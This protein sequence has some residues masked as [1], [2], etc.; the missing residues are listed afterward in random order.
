MRYLVAIFLILFSMQSFADET[1]DELRERMQLAEAP[2]NPTDMQSIERGAK[3]FANTCMSCHTMVYLKYDKLAKKAGI[4][5]D[6]MPV[7]VKDWPYGVKPPDLS[8]EA[9]LRGVNWLYTYLHSF[10][11]DKERPTGANN[12][13]V[14]MT[15]M[16]AILSPYQGEQALVKKAYGGGILYGDLQWYDLVKLTRQGT[17]T[18]EQ[19]DA[20]VTDLVNFLAYASQPFR[21]EQEKLGIWVIAFL[22]ILF[23]FIYFLKLDYWKDVKYRK[24]KE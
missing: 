1:L 8:S 23:V 4:T 13:L 10:Y 5:Y 22:C 7:N 19:F 15:A 6:K 17:M 16:P 24:D 2:V 12:L 14:P 21:V 3:F 18:P 20:T 9:D 11:V